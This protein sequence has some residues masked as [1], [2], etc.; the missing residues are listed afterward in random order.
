[1]TGSD[2]NSHLVNLDAVLT[3]LEEYGLK[4]N[5]KKCEFFKES[6]EYCGHKIDKQGL[7]KTQDKIEAIVKSPQPEN[8]SLLRSFLRLVNYYHKFLPNLSTVLHP[9]NAAA[10]KHK[11]GLD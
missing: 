5:R 6:I 4:A 11:V 1:M 2:K 9:L 8:V 10:S 7:H 3:K